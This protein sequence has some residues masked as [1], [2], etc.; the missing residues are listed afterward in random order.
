MIWALAGAV[1][2]EAS[3]IIYLLSSVDRCLRMIRH[4]QSII[5]TTQTIAKQNCDH[6]DKMIKIMK[7]TQS[8]VKSLAA[9]AHFH[10]KR[11]GSFN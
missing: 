3:I 2:A 1:I 9:V 5:E 8:T 10:D 11:D 7:E 4:L 6:T